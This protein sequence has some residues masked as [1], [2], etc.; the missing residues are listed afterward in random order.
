PGGTVTVTSA[1]RGAYCNI[2]RCQPSGGFDVSPSGDASFQK[3][4]VGDPSTVNIAWGSTNSQQSERDAFYHV[5]LAHDYVK[6][7]DPTY[8]AND[9][10]L[11][12]YVDESDNC[13]AM[14]D[15]ATNTLN[16]LSAGLGCPNTAT[17]PDIVYHEYSHSVADNLY[18]SRG[19]PQGMQN[20]ALHEGLADAFTAYMTGD[21]V[22]GDGFFGTGT[23]LRT[24][25][26]TKQWPQ[27]RNTVEPEGTGGILAGAM[28]DLRLSVG[29]A[30]AAHITHFAKYGLADDP[31][32]DV[33][34][35]EY[36]VDV[37]VADDNDNNLSNGTPHYSQIVN[38]FN[39]HGIGTNYFIDVN[40]T[41]D[42]QPN[43]GPFPVT[44]V[45]TY[46]GVFG[47]LDVTSP[48]LFYS[49][50]GAAFASTPMFPTGNPDEYG[51]QLPARTSTVVRYYVRATTTDGGVKTEPA[52]AP[53]R[54][55]SFIGGL[56]TP[57]IANDFDTDM[58][59]TVGASGDAATTGIWVRSDPVGSAIQ[60][61]DDH[62]PSGTQCY[63]TGNALP[64]DGPGV[65]DVDG[66]ATTLVS[67]TFD[68]TPPNEIR[69][70]ISYWRWF[71]N[72]AGDNP[73]QDPWKVEISNNGGSTWTT[74]ENT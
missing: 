68:V 37:L 73:G 43:V 38:A 56:F 28:S 66:G 1:L 30:T 60:P 15:F 49:I 69:P 32:D 36:F 17:M 4:S 39:A 55:Y 11:T 8:V 67:S 42:D 12:T 16:F 64:G 21:P 34:F 6:S 45:I 46:N 24:C 31:R 2:D 65:N 70:V 40:V 20:G 47:G 33:A 72:N 27:D 18:V 13:N 50:N 57:V 29:A 63:V 7:L 10:E 25:A 19:R 74:V 14:W 52:G 9:Y 35:S 51:A 22:I 48:T 26:N 61:E 23:S 53:S 62:S 44:A 71:T 5:N 54:A 59:W 3:H 58:G 41:A